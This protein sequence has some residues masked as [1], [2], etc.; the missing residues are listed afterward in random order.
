M[1]ILCKSVQGRHA[2]NSEVLPYPYF[3]GLYS[4]PTQPKWSPPQVFILHDLRCKSIL[5]L[6]E[7]KHSMEV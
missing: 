4:P 6:Y 7:E 3:D 5:H 1:I 2:G